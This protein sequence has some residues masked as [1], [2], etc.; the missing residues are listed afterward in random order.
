MKKKEGGGRE[1]EHSSTGNVLQF[2][3]KGLSIMVCSRAL[4]TYVVGTT[5]A[6]LCAS[7][8]QTYC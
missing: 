6:V 8:K 3:R 7:A 2:P 5:Y 1:K 4:P